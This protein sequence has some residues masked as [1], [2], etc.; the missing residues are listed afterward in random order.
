MVAGFHGRGLLFARRIVQR[1]LVEE[2]DSV[3]QCG[4][5]AI[6]L[7]AL[8]SSDEHRGKKFGSCDDHPIGRVLV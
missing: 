2:C 6:P 7:Q 4:N 1:L 8:V 5:A 3:P